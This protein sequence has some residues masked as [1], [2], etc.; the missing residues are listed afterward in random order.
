[1]DMPAEFKVEFTATLENEADAELLGNWLRGMGLG[2]V[3]YAVSTGLKPV[4]VPEDLANTLASSTWM[5][6]VSDERLTEL[7]N[8]AQDA[9]QGA[10][11]SY[12]CSLGIWGELRYKPEVS[13]ESVVLAAVRCFKHQSVRV[14]LSVVVV[15]L[16]HACEQRN[17]PCPGQMPDVLTSVRVANVWAT[18][19]VQKEDIPRQHRLAPLTMARLLH[20]PGVPDFE[21]R[22]RIEHLDAL[23]REAVP[24]S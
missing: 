6:S 1:M 19:V 4:K 20:L 9:L 8:A 5:A 14:R 11:A 7:L 16:W 23:V 22:R 10:D 21:V 18:G 12:Q 2:C 17:L 13:P 3:G 24:N 15:T